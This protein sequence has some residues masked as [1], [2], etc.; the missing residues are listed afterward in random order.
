MGECD[1]KNTG[2]WIF[3][4]EMDFYSGLKVGE[5]SMYMAY[6]EICYWYEG[7]VL[8]GLFRVYIGGEAGIDTWF[9]EGESE[10]IFGW[11]EEMVSGEF[12]EGVGLYTCE[13]VYGDCGM[14][15]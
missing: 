7:Y 12:Q 9:C 6:E 10:D 15:V 5:G 3:I 13:D 11:Y 1:G 4:V 14:Q 8:A 2:K